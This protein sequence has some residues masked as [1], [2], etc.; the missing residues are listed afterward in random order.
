[1][2]ISLIL[3]LWVKPAA[4]FRSLLRTAPSLPRHPGTW[5]RRTPPSSLSPGLQLHIPVHHHPT[6]LSAASA[7][8]A[9]AKRE[10]RAPPSFINGPLRRAAMKLHT[11]D[12]AKEGEQP[13]Q[14]PFTKWAPGLADFMQFLVDSK[15]VFETLERCVNETAELKALRGSGL[16]RT[17]A[18][19]RDVR[20]L[21]E[22]DPSL[23]VPPVGQPGRAYAELLLSKL[24]EGIPVFMNH[25]YNTYF[26]HSAGGR[27]IGRRMCDTLLGGHLLHFYRWEQ[28]DTHTATENHHHHEQGHHASGSGSGDRSVIEG[29]LAGVREKIDRMALS[30]TE[31]EK[32]KCI[33]E[34]PNAFRYG[35]GLLS[36]LAKPPKESAGEA[37]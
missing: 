24:D 26:A 2:W 22:L 23:S 14:T 9:E 10:K 32:Q 13:A 3:G 27:M 19:D 12:Q 29:L 18:L 20:Y 17:A 33:D 11:R 7:T 5:S 21:L 6:S 25:Y 16:E 30:W 35:G 1:M 28:P 34:T 15:H 36:H 37:V 8:E 31:E 4:A